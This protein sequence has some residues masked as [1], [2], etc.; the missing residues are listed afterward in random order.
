MSARTRLTLEKR[1][2]F[3]HALRLGDTVKH[4]AEHI[5]IARRSLYD[6]RGADVG[7]AS[8][9]NDAI[10]EGNE[11]LEQAAI[12][13]GRDGWEEPVFHRGEQI[14]VIR[15][16]SDTLLIFMLKGRLPEKY[17]EHYSAKIDARVSNPVVIPEETIDAVLSYYAT[18]EWNSEQTG[19]L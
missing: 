19:N 6:L 7:F 18:R 13:R 12:R 16:Y 1:A 17:R 11:A 15:R 2:K 8:E 9:W 3:L 5:Q 4:A 14:G 10:E